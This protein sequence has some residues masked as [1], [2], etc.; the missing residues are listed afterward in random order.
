MAEKKSLLGQIDAKSHLENSDSPF[1]KKEKTKP[2]RIRESYYEEI[3]EIAF[4]QK[5]KMVD[6]LD[7]VLKRGLKQFRRTHP[8]E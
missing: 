7:D 3:R 5:I 2:M 8:D 6:V 4:K 1:N